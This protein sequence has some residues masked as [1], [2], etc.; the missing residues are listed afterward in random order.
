MTAAQALTRIEAIQRKALSA[1]AYVA[2]A[3]VMPFVPID[4]GALRESGKVIDNAQDNE[5]LLV[6]GGQGSAGKN[7]GAATP[8]KYVSNQYAKAK[9]HFLTGGK[10]GRILSLFTGT[11]KKNYRGASNKSRYAAAY[12]QAIK[13]D[14]LTVFPNGVRWFKIILRSA[15][16]R[17]K[18]ATTYA[19]AVNGL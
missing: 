8:D 19:R 5:V 14:S 2:L 18:M 15:E 11:A 9:K 4:S 16:I 17:R 10:L 6:F 7:P 1:S 3:Q 13:N 12:R